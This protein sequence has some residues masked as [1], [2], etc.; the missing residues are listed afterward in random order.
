MDFSQ[1][2]TDWLNLK[3]WEILMEEYTTEQEHFWAGDFGDGYLKRNRGEQLVG[4]KTAFFGR[5]LRGAGAISSIMEFGCNIGLNLQALSQ[6][7]SFKLSGIEINTNAAGQAASLGVA[8]ISNK[9]ILNDL[10]GEGMFD[11]T[12]TMGVLIHINPDCLTT[13]YDNLV[14]LSRRYILV[15]EYYNPSPVSVTYRGHEDRLF[16]RDFAGDLM[17][18]H[19]LR[20][21]DY[22]FVYHRDN[23]MPLDDCTWFLLEKQ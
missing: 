17:D 5:A 21:C 20:L 15:A 13:V 12:F 4:A 23:V 22:G 19:R 1:P 9:S 2:R 14:A 8:K 11:L 6:L 16:K 10:T 18:R 3:L 7:G